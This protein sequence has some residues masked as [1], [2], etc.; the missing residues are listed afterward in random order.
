MLSDKAVVTLATVCHSM[1]ADI[2]AFVICIFLL[3]NL[4]AY[5]S[6]MALK[7]PQMLLCWCPS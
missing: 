7:T 3:K 6:V 4:S 5:N 1:P 2:I